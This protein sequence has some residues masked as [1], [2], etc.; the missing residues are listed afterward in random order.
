M[1]GRPVERSQQ[2]RERPAADTAWMSKYPGYDSTRL[3]AAV[4]AIYDELNGK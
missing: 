3:Q 2:Q 1:E 4:Q